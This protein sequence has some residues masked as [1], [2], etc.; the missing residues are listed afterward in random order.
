VLP[1]KNSNV[2]LLAEN[3]MRVLYALDPQ[4]ARQAVAVDATHWQLLAHAAA[5]FGEYALYGSG[6][7]RSLGSRRLVLRRGGVR[8]IVHGVVSAL[9]DDAVFSRPLAESAIG[10]CPSALEATNRYANGNPKPPASIRSV[11]GCV[12]TGV[13]EAA[14]GRAHDALIRAGDAQLLAS[15]HAHVRPPDSFVQRLFTGACAR[16]PSPLQ[17]TRSHPIT[18]LRG[19]PSHGTPPQYPSTPA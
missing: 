11:S 13:S 1:R 6:P 12:F 15:F 4:G 5:P 10:A 9:V 16:P 3:V 19:T 17:P 18:P 14:Y 8:L 2:H 7:T